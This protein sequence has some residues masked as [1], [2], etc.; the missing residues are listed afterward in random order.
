[1]RRVTESSC[2]PYGLRAG[3]RRRGTGLACTR[4][5][6]GKGGRV[7]ESVNVCNGYESAEMPFVTDRA[8]GTRTLRYNEVS[9]PRL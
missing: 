2:A 6:S 8:R 5:H 7:T 9:N 4:S 1:M 3:D